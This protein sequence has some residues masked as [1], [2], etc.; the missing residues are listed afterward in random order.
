MTTDQATRRSRSASGPA[1][2][3]TLM[4]MTV[5]L[6]ITGLLLV[7]LGASMKVA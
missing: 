2:A 6:A 1:R 4:E 3:F 7:A 5:S